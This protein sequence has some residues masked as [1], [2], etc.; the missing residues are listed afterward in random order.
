MRRLKREAKVSAQKDKERRTGAPVTEPFWFDCE[1]QTDCRP[2]LSQCQWTAVNG[3]WL[4]AAK[5][6]AGAAPVAGCK[7][8]LRDHAPPTYCLAKKCWIR[9]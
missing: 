5:K 3:H 2:Y 6:S 4:A 9:R 7:K 1:R 8:V